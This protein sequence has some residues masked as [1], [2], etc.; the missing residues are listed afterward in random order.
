MGEFQDVPVLVISL[1]PA[2]VENVQEG[3]QRTLL[4]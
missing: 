4:T 2:G 1:V 3:K